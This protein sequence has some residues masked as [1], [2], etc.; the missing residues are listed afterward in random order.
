MRCECHHIL[1]LATI[2]NSNFIFILQVF[3]VQPPRHYSYY[4]YGVIPISKSQ[5]INLMTEIHP[6]LKYP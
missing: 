1:R 2:D 3:Q 6:V 4:I 5:T